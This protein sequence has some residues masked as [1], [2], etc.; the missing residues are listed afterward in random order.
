MKSKLTA[1]SIIVLVLLL[2]SAALLCG[3]WFFRAAWYGEAELFS[4]EHT[5]NAH[6]LGSTVNLTARCNLPWGQT[7][8]SAVWQAGDGVFQAGDIKI[9]SGKISAKGRQQFI[10]VPLKSSRT[11]KV[12]AGTLTVNIQR[13]LFKDKVRQKSFTLKQPN[14]TVEPLKIDDKNQLPLADA[15]TPISPAGNAI[16]YIAGGALLLL[17]V[18]L[19]WFILR[20]RPHSSRQLPPWEIARQELMDL[21]RAAAE[22]PLAW[23]IA[24][25]TDVVRSY[26]ASRFNYPAVTQTT[27][28]FFTTL[29]RQN[30][31][32]TSA[33]IRYLEDFLSAADL[34]KFA[35]LSP[36]K[37]MFENAAVKAE[38]LIDETGIPDS[39][40]N[41]GNNK[42]GK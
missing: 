11:G 6:R 12:D 13:P 41:S 16:W 2:T 17:A 24:Q 27:E 9:R 7:I 10:T 19:V 4:E 14:F 34:V 30:T 38:K 8:K 33:Q 42:Q 32:L 40:P 37:D 1:V 25:L 35:N 31:Q 23:C 3:V 39:E 21:R 29:R 15:L 5:I 36:E 22:R 20:R 28:E 18:I 26:L